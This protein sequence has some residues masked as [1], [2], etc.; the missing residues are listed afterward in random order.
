[1]NDMQTQEASVTVLVDLPLARAWQQL[2]DFSLAHNYVPKLTRTEIVSELQSGVGAHRRV[3]TGNKYLE[4]TIVEWRE[5][6][7]FSIKLHKGSKPMSPFSLAEFIYRLGE[8]GQQQ[9]RIDLS[10]R[11]AMPWGGLG[12]LLGGAVILP[13]MRKQLVQVAAGMKHFY[14]TGNPATDEDRKRLAGAV[15][16]GSASQ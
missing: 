6:Q 10:L 4:E 9:T 12:R 13:V 5:G 8:Q 2:Q 14:E 7:G 1:M 3:Y 11:F 16:I 15:Q